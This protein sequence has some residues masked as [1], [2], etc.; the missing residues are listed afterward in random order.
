MLD[1]LRHQLAYEAVKYACSR[2][3][4][5]ECGTILDV[6]DA[7]L[8]TNAGPDVAGAGAGVSCG[9]CFDT[10][11]EETAK[12]HGISFVGAILLA[13]DGGADIDDGRVLRKLLRNAGALS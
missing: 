7:V 11:V 2:R 4:M 5:C 1:Y 10:A 8:V 13:T 3:M 6:D 9:E 12:K